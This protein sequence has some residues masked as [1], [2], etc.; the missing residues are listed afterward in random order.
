MR[1]ASLCI[2][3]GI[4]FNSLYNPRIPLV[5]RRPAS[6]D[7][8]PQGIAQPKKEQ[9]KAG[10]ADPAKKKG[11][12]AGGNDMHAETPVPPSD[13]DEKILFDA[14]SY[15]FQ[16]LQALVSYDLF[17]MIWILRGSILYS[18]TVIYEPP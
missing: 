14:A 13:D 2:N 10:G 8:A 15:V 18:P 7:F 16:H 5:P 11:G 9:K 6:A 3:S 12:A 17:A 4:T 1:A